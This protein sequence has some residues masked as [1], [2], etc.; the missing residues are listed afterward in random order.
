MK[1]N[2]NENLV[3]LNVGSIFKDD[4]YIIPI[5]QRNYDWGKN[6]I[7]QLIFD[8]ND[9]IKENEDYYIGTLI[10]NDKGAKNFEV[11]DGQ[12][13]LTTIFLMMSYFKHLNNMNEIN[14]NFNNHLEFESRPKSTKMLSKVFEKEDDFNNKD[15]SIISGY[16]VIKKRFNKGLTQ[17]GN[18]INKHIFYKYFVERV[19][20]LKVVVPEGTDLNHYFEIMNT[21]GEQLEAHE[22]IKAKM[23]SIIENKSSNEEAERKLFNIIWEAS[24]NMERYVQYGI[25]DTKLRECIFGENWNSFEYENFEGILS[26]E[27]SQ[28]D[29]K[30]KNNETKSISIGKYLLDDNKLEGNKLSILQ[31][32]E[33]QDDLKPSDFKINDNY[34]LEKDSIR[35]TPV[36]NFPN[37]LLQV[38]RVIVGNC[39]TNDCVDENCYCNKFIEDTNEENEILKDL[40]PLDDKRLIVTFLNILSE[41]SYNYRFAKEFAYNLLKFRFFLDKFVIKREYT[42]DI[43]DWSLKRLKTYNNNHKKTQN[44]V[45]TYSLNEEDVVGTDENTTILM[46]LSMFHVSNPSQNYKHWLTGVLNYLNSNFNNDG[47]G[48]NSSEYINFLECLAERFLQERYLTDNPIGYDDL[49]FNHTGYVDINDDLLNKGIGV[50]NFIFNYLDYK[51]WKDKTINLDNKEKFQFSFKSSVEHFYPQNPPKTDI[52]LEKKNDKFVNIDNFGNLC[53]MSQDMNSRFTNN[54][55][56]SKV[57]NFK[58]DSKNNNLFSLKQRIMF[59]MENWESKSGNE[60]IWRDAEIIKHGC[61]M[62]KILLNLKDNKCES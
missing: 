17:N 57:A 61:E 27:S 11:I 25:S 1:K 60:K 35:F 16:N 5:Y 54:L 29:D 42:S 19:K 8:I 48:I 32:V 24:S 33:L 26:K 4:K 49:I 7:S 6:E 36:I 50:E 45:A 23:L 13:R 22:I 52:S 41:D 18:E 30:K 15:S 2:E 20:L 3:E 12:Q 14:L 31:I 46:L 62:K 58:N 37:F 55:P 44:Y 9:K 34:K 28:L 21:R 40:I 43:D 47:Q 59:K 39:K 56:E 38:L 10:V 51:L 53:L